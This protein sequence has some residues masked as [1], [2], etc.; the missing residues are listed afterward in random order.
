MK[1]NRFAKQLIYLREEAG[2]KQTEL[3]KELGVTKQA[4]SKWE[5]GLRETDF[6]MLIKIAEY[7]NVTT[8]YLLGLED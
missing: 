1:V 6:D 2:L 8:D 4:I 7:F 3:A 5:K